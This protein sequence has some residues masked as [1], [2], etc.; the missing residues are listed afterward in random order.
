MT[1]KEQSAAERGS[2][3]DDVARIRARGEE[4]R[5]RTQAVGAWRRPRTGEALIERFWKVFRT[6]RVAVFGLI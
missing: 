3:K 4:G 2:E 6:C 1:I 5:K